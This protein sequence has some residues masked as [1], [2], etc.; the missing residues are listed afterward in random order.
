[1]NAVGY[2]T[3]RVARTYAVL[4]IVIFTLVMLVVTLGMRLH[5][6]DRIIEEQNEL[7]TL[8]EQMIWEVGQ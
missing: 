7:I 2:R 5:L 6:A 3:E 1:M 4:G 8:Q